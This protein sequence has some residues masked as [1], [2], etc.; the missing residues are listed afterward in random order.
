MRPESQRD[1]H[2]AIAAWHEEGPEGASLHAF[3]G[4]SWEQ[5]RVWAEGGPLPSDCQ[6]YDGVRR[7]RRKS[8]EARRKRALLKAA[9][10][11]A[12]E[13]LGSLHR[14]QYQSLLAKHIKLLEAG[15][16]KVRAGEDG[17]DAGG[18]SSASYVV[19]ADEDAGVRGVGEVVSGGFPAVAGGGAQEP[20]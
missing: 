2:Q 9:R 3:L 12:L 6:W 10:R 20:A 5:Y 11:R 17:S 1:I 4:L 7:N 18:G 19:G 13:E 14:P 15:V 8:A 16:E